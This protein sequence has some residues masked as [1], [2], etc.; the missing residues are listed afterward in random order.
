MCASMDWKHLWSSKKRHIPV[1]NVG[2]SYQSMIENAVSV[3]KN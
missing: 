2:E 3:K 1:Q